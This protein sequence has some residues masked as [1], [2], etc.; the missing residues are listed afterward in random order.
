MTITVYNA[1]KS[2]WYSS[3]VGAQ[4]EVVEYSRVYDAYLVE[5]APGVQRYIYKDDCEPRDLK[6]EL[7]LVEQALLNL[8][9]GKRLNEVRFEFEN[10]KAVTLTRRTMPHFVHEFEQMLKELKR[11]V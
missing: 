1:P 10:G 4:F 11:K 9:D 2:H 6:S 8:S 3:M 5:V 7:T